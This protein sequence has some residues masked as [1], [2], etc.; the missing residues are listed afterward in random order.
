MSPLICP[1]KARIALFF[2]TEGVCDFRKKCA[3]YGICKI[4]HSELNGSALE[5]KLSP[6][7]LNKSSK[8]MTRCYYSQ[9]ENSE[10]S[11]TTSVSCF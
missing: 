3:K 4:V 1:K 6:K 5:V 8:L 11:G 9:Y 7:H 10:K 2:G